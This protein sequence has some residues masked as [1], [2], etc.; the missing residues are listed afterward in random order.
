MEA[1]LLQ[2]A[3]LSEA[4]AVRFENRTTRIAGD[5][6]ERSDEECR[7]LRQLAG[8]R[9]YGYGASRHTG[10]SRMS[11][12]PDEFAC[13]G[14][15]RVDAELIN[16]SDWLA[17]QEYSE[18]VKGHRPAAHRIREILIKLLP[19]VTEI[20]LKPE[21]SS[22]ALRCKTPDGW[23]SMD[24]LSLGYQT[25]IAWTVDL[26]SRLYDRYEHCDDP[27]A[28][29]AIALVDEIDLHLHPRLQR[30]VLG[31]LTETFPNTQFIATAHSP[32]IVQAAGDANVVLLQRAGDHVEIINDPIQVSNWR[33]DQI[34]TSDLFGLDGPRSPRIE[35][36][37]EERRQLL[38][39]R[40]EPAGDQLR[41]VAELEEEIG[42]LPSGE[43]PREIRLMEAVQHLAETLK[44]EAEHR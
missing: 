44:G 30:E 38:S 33:V 24:K 39:Q 19:D 42:N 4:N 25:L 9:C 6:T 10:G 17:T 32:L 12:C 43:S 8:F 41:R 35:M 21:S 18:K 22:L 14:L 2:G 27:L 40:E 16:P 11:S 13:R 34:L 20:D 5:T 28:G 26:A 36:L 37:L 7:T 1:K 23:V 29:P 3:C 31:I 15:F